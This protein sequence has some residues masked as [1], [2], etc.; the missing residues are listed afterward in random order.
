MD[1]NDS[2]YYL[3]LPYPE[4][5][6]RTVCA[7]DA[8][9]TEDRVIG[10]QYS[11]ESMTDRERD[12]LDYRFRE[13]KTYREIS[14]R[15]ELPVERIRVIYERSMRKLRKSFRFDL[16]AL[17]YYTAEEK[18][19]KTEEAEKRE[20]GEAFRKAVEETGNPELLTMPV[21]ELNLSVRILNSLA[22]QQ[23]K[24]V[25]DLWIISQRHPE[26]YF[27][28]RGIGEI[29]QKEISDRLKS[30]GFNLKGESDNGQI[31]T[32]LEEEQEGTT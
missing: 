5:L 13:R 17:G 31:C 15:F 12:V 4:N 10:L 20:D 24:T 32:A 1:K 8:E 27:R 30:L 6:I 11:L 25:S 28:V 23:I 14:D 29:G 18:R 21:S 26:D 22:W 16:I 2:R 7:D 19:K 9:I 3:S